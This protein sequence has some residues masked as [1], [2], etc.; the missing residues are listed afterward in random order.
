MKARTLFAAVQALLL[1]LLLGGGGYFVLNDYP[2]GWLMLGMGLALFLYDRRGVFYTI[3]AN[4]AFRSGGLNAALEWLGRAWQSKALDPH[5]Q[6]TYAYLLMKA[7]RWEEAREAFA[8]MERRGPWFVGE[9]ERPLLLTYRSM[10]D[11]HD[12]RRQEAIGQLWALVEEGYRTLALLTTLGAYLLD[13]GDWEGLER[14]VALGRDYDPHDPGL[15]DNEA[16]FALA[17]D[18]LER[19]G[20]ILE[21]ELIPQ[22]PSFPDAWIHYA[23]YLRRCGRYEEATRAYQR[24]LELP[25]HGLS[26]CTRE[27]IEKELREVSA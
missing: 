1:V 26:A 22:N 20:R 7:N 11:W 12:G 17:T 14:V 18:Q 16:A 8:A 24:A 10:L 21:Q 25:F 19:A 6:V 4:L 27:A 13:L 2:Y 9:D 15:L 5:T 23:R 3:M